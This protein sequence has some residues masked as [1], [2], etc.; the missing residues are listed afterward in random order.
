M[1]VYIV[2]QSRKVLTVCTSRGPEKSVT[3]EDDNL[4]GQTESVIDV[5]R[6]SAYHQSPAVNFNSTLG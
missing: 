3:S 2:I 6:Q 4:R 5:H 1:Y